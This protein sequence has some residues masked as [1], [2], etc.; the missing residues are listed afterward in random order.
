ML[1]KIEKTI[2]G[3]VWHLRELGAREKLNAQGAGE[4]GDVVLAMACAGIEGADGLEIP[5]DRVGK[6]EWANEYFANRLEDLVEIVNSVA[7]LSSVS[8]EGKGPSASPPA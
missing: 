1:K 2:G 4:K 6:I 8:A 3:V 7:S 5:H